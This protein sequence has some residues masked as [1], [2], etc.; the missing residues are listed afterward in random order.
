[1][2]PFQIA[3]TG[4]EEANALHTT[5]HQA[6]TLWPASVFSN[7]HPAMVAR[8]LPD[9]WARAIAERGGVPVPNPVGVPAP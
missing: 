6:R 7:F 2:Y 9:A 1:V 4:P 8:A 5:A 3:S